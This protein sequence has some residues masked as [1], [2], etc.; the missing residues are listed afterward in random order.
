M[1]IDNNKMDIKI[2]ESYQGYGNLFGKEKIK[3]IRKFLN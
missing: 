1:S 2:G 3:N